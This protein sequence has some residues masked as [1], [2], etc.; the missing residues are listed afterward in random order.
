MDMVTRVQT[1]NEAVCIS[2]G[3]NTLIKG[4]RLNILSP[5]MGKQKVI[6]GPLT[7]V[8]QLVKEKENFEFKFVKFHLK[9]DLVSHPASAEELGKNRLWLGQCRLRPIAPQNL[10][11]VQVLFALA[12]THS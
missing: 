11:K 3:T 4:M 1:L 10:R 6:L 12:F 8:G 5:G 2:H 9:I 7:F